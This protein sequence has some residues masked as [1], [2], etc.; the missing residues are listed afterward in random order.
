VIAV[1][2]PGRLAARC[3]AGP[4]CDSI[5]KFLPNDTINDSRGPAHRS[6]RTAYSFKPRK[7]V[8]VPNVN[9]FGRRLN[10]PKKRENRLELDYNRLGKEC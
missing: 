8:E 3:D 4:S 2:E 10:Q 1:S 9:L 7:A 6:G 5:S